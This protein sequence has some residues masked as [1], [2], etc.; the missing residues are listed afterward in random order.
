MVRIAERNE[1]S[2][3]RGHITACIG[4]AETLVLTGLVEAIILRIVPVLCT[5]LWNLVKSDECEV[6]E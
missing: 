2:C 1:R 4:I 5:S 3:R 6:C